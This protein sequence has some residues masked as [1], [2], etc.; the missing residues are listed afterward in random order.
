MLIQ[1][2]HQQVFKLLQ[3]VWQ[4]FIFV[5]VKIMIYVGYFNNFFEVKQLYLEF[6]L[7]L[8]VL[9]IDH[10]IQFLMIIMLL[11]ILFF[12]VRLIFIHDIKLILHQPRYI[13]F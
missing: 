12:L 6:V 13:N 1:Q 3:V 11:L 8:F 10:F 7:N 2:D 9:L 4:Q 5:I